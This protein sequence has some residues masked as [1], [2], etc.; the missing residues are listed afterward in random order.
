MAV[1]SAALAG[2]GFVAAA[3][4]VIVMNEE[5]RI[6]LTGP[7]VIEQEMGKDDLTL[8]TMLCL[9]DNRRQT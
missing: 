4:D 1:K 6:G 9:P 7:E 5:G 8:P 3:T 2:M